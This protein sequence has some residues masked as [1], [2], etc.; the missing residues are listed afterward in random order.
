MAAILED[1]EARVGQ[2]LRHALGL[3]EGAQPV[4]A[5]GDHQRG[6]G[7]AFE[8]GIAV[9]AH[10]GGLALAHLGAKSALHAA[11]PV[12]QHRIGVA[13]GVQPHRVG[14]G[15]GGAGWP[16]ARPIARLAAC[17][18]LVGIAAR[19]RGDEC[20]ARHALRRHQREHACHE[21]THREADQHETLGR[22]GQHAPRHAFERIVFID[23]AEMK[24]AECF[25]IGDHVGPQIGVA[26]E[27]GEQD[28][29]TH[30]G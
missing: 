14:G 6:A 22:F 28:E 1:A 19:G 21:A 11:Q 26:H 4:L 16:V 13:V 20:H 15:A 30:A 8:I 25:E 2:C 12:E 5:A 29:G 9:A 18:L 23:V 3:G 7:D 10:Q 27:A 24:G 17:A